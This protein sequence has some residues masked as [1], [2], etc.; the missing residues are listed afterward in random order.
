MMGDFDDVP[1]QAAPPPA[2]SSR[3]GEV[4]PPL[5]ENL[6]AV[7]TTDVVLAE[8]PVI[9][10]Q[11]VYQP[12]G[13]EAIIARLEAEVRAFKGDISTEKGRGEIKSLAHKVSRTKSL[14][15]E[16][17]KELT[18]GWK[19]AAKV[20]DVDRKKIRDRLDALRDEARKP[21]DDWEEYEE[22]RIQGH[23]D[24]LTV[25]EDLGVFTFGDDAEP[26]AK[27]V[28]DRIAVIEELP[29]RDWQEFSTQVADRRAALLLNL[30]G[31]LKRAQK[32]E[33]DAAEL[34]ELRRQQAQRAAD[35]EAARAAAEAARIA[36]EQRLAAEQEAERVRLAEEQ[37]QREEAERIR[38]AAEEARI[39]AE[40]AA[41]A[42]AERV[43]L[44]NETAAR[45][46]AERAEAAQAE[47]DRVVEA[48]RQRLERERVA[49][50][51]AQQAA[52]A[53][54]EENRIAGEKAAAAAAQK[55]IDDERARVAADQ[56]REN[57]A[58]LDRE[59][60]KQH[61]AKINGEVLAALQQHA[62]LTKDGAKAVVVAIAQ[63]K[64]AHTKI[65]Y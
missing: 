58:A 9:T 17:G 54:A 45:E 14:L 10:A 23:R 28:H 63:G 19:K 41:A 22:K 43:R 4:L 40:Q 24:A 59:K 8:R 15:D 37:R 47:R 20:V 57:Q 44:A 7:I 51:E 13:P 61:N 27:M 56:V 16:M 39:A 18:E 62:G 29:A 48:E 32:R 11:L 46:A 35:E 52:I 1:Q 6:P 30:G 5:P 12:G 60:N 64:I 26:T 49:A 33:S 50:V 3:G 42:E 38:V 21:V 31:M 25:L 34:A 65:S 2:G 53:K 55:A 36:E